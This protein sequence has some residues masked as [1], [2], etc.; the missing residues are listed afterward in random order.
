M[1]I[2][3]KYGK[4]AGDVTA[5]GHDNWIELNS[6]DWGVSR[7][8]KTDTGSAA[9]REST[10]PTVHEVSITK[11]MDVATPLLL[12]QALQGKGVEVSI[13]LCKTDQDQ[14]KTYVE[15]VLHNCLLSNFN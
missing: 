10:A 2:Y 9:D 7:A 15:Y 5:E 4:I 1:P 14:L 12:Q 3:M 13:H 8:I 11:M 6:L